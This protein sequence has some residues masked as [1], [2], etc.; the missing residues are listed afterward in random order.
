MRP[1]YSVMS[2]PPSPISKLLR[3]SRQLNE[4]QKHCC[5]WPT[6]EKPEHFCLRVKAHKEVLKQY[7]CAYSSLD[8]TLDYLQHIIQ[9]GGLACA[10]DVSH[11]G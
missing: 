1:H 8:C 11:N 10:E 5:K 9:D 6:A 7:V 4:K 2:P 3:G